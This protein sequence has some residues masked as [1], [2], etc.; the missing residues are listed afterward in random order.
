VLRSWWMFSHP[1]YLNTS[2]NLLEGVGAQLR[3][4]KRP[5][6]LVARPVRSEAAKPRQRQ[7]KGQASSGKA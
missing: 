5:S 4:A 1:F 2:L 3:K 7:D 6:R